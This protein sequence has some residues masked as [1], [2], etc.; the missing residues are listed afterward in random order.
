LELES[1][2][3]LFAELGAIPELRDVQAILEPVGPAPGGLSEREIEV[4]RLVAA[5]MTNH[6][7]A[8][9]LYI[10]ERTVH[11]HVS[12]IFTKIGVNSRTAAAAYAAQRGLLT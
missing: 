2:K 10:S 4:L 7:I 1:A 6:A 12:N 8:A 9:Q 5:G 11:R 3:Q